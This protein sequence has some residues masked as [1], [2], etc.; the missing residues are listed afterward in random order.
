MFSFSEVINKKNKKKKRKNY[1]P[2]EMKLIHRCVLQ[3]ILLTS[4]I[5]IDKN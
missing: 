5:L 2:T 3:R 1:Y 4:Y